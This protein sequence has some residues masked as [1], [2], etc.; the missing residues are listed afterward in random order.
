M[1]IIFTRFAAMHTLRHRLSIVS[2]VIL[3][4]SCLIFT[5]TALSQRDGLFRRENDK[6]AMSERW[7]LDSATRKKPLQITAY[8]PV[9]VT[10]GR[11]SSN[12]NMQPTSGN[13][14]YSLPFKVA[15]NNYEAKFQFSLKTKAIQGIFWG[16]GDLWVAYTQKAHWQIYNEKLSRPFRELN[17]EP[18]LII[19]FAT[20][21]TILGFTTRMVGAAFNHQSNGRTLPLSRSW[22]RIIFHA[23]LE[24]KNWQVYIKPWL[25]LADKEDENPDITSYIGS[26]ELTVIRSFGRHQVSVAG[27]HSVRFTNRWG[28]GSIQAN[29]VFP[30]LGNLKGML[31]VS[32]GY[33]E[34]L[35]DYNHRQTT[36]GLSVS[37]VEW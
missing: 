13:P 6:Q 35:V 21:F 37:L 33:G 32:E 26:G 20:R 22:N 16:K 3:T 29:W 12:P 19:N 17:Y 25:R 5:A 11:W 9:Y 24:R 2:R 36:V 34:T 7:E 27:S 10:A 1:Q 8:K 31:Q 18:E 30:V 14:V 28:R 23:G 15:Y 4:C